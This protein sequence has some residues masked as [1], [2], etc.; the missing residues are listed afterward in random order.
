[1]SGIVLVWRQVRAISERWAGPIAKATP[2]AALIGP[3]GS[4][5]A[6]GVT[7]PAGAAGPTG[8][9]GPAGPPGS[10]API[11]AVEIDLGTPARR[12]GRF[13]MTVTGQTF[14]K[15]VAIWQAP[16]PYTGKGFASA[17]EAEMDAL[18]V[19]ASVTSATTITAFWRSRHRVRGNFKFAYQIG[20]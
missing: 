18:T 5:G 12:S 17:D 11:T 7:G 16:G 6:P 13:I 4:P 10:G 15:P 2:L 3:P 1:M 20:G 19:S 9:Q 8:P 14:G